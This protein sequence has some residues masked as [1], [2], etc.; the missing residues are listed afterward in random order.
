MT[1]VDTVIAAWGAA[2]QRPPI[3]VFADH[4]GTPDEQVSVDGWVV[5]RAT[6]GWGL[7]S[8]VLLPSYDKA[9]PPELDLI[10]LGEWP[11]LAEATD[12]LILHASAVAHAQRE[13]DPEIPF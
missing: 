4:E 13:P 1:T 7:A 12:A 10:P 5:Y 11:T 6:D 9:L 2:F 8:E 3:R